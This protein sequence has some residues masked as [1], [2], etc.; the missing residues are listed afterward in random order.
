MPTIH[1]GDLG[2]RIHTMHFV[3]KCKQK[4]CLQE[5]STGNLLGRFDGAAGS[6]KQ[7][8]E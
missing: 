6:N 4:L 5:N 1:S 3:E 2:T 7:A 8:Q